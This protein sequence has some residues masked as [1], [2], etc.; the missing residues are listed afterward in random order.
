VKLHDFG[1]VARYIMNGIR[2]QRVQ[3]ATEQWLVLC[4][5]LTRLTL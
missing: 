1:Q 5:R 2:G 4:P 3:V